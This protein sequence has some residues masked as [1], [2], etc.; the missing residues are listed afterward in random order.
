MHRRLGV[1]QE[2]DRD[3]QWAQRGVPEKGRTR[4]LRSHRIQAE[5][6][7]CP[8]LW[9]GRSPRQY[10]Q[11]P[12]DRCNSPA[13]LGKSPVS[14]GF[15]FLV[16]KALKNTLASSQRPDVTA[17]GCA[18]DGFLGSSAAPSVQPDREPAGSAA[19]R[20]SSSSDEAM[21]HVVHLRLS[22][23][24]HHVQLYTHHNTGCVGLETAFCS[25]ILTVRKP[26]QRRLSDPV[27]LGD[28]TECPTFLGL[29]RDR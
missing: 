6:P 4:P 2:S 12:G 27:K 13:A 20:S 5:A 1:H 19:G 23:D 14:P 21:P 3:L 15:C 29:S 8:H 16:W 25:F 28:H 26:D 22:E 9:R 11:F 24:R 17:L 7:N 10:R 18:L